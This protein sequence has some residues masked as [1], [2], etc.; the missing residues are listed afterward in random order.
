MLHSRFILGLKVKAC[1]PT[2]KLDI[3]RD[4][5]FVVE[6]TINPRCVSA[7]HS[8]TSVKAPT[9]FG[10]PQAIEHGL[11]DDRKELETWETR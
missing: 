7:R 5:N 6:R 8:E 2:L 3:A 1:S 4:R 11:R 9:L 10:H